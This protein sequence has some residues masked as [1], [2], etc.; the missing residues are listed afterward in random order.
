MTKT[1]SNPYISITRIGLKFKFTWGNS[2]IYKLYT[3]LINENKL[4]HEIKS[5][6]N[7]NRALFIHS[8]NKIYKEVITE[9]MKDHFTITVNSNMHLSHGKF[10]YCCNSMNWDILANALF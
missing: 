10:L 2:I 1:Y 8:Y 4:S 3:M 7:E 5:S 9:I 6:L